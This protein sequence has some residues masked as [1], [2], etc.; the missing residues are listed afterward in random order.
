[1]TITD[2]HKEEEHHQVDMTIMDLHAV[3]WVAVVVNLTTMIYHHE[4]DQT[5]TT[6]I[7]NRHHVE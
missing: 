6:A 5:T 3:E 7:K 1:M 2:H 4:E